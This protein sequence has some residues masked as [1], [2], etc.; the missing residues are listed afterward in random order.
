MKR[1]VDLVILSDVHLGTYGCRAQELLQYLR[2]IK[3]R[4]LILNGDIVD[5]WQ[6]KKATSLIHIYWLSSIFLNSPVRIPKSFISQAITTRCFA[7][8]QMCISEIFSSPIK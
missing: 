8:L 6:F 1:E 2:S 4:K 3:P 7:N 5:I